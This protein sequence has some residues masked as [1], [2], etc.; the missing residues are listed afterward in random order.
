MER[1]GGASLHE[2]GAGGAFGFSGLEGFA[3]DADPGFAEAGEAAGM[4]DFSGAVDFAGA[5]SSVDLGASPRRASTI[6][7]VPVLLI[8]QLR[9]QMRHCASV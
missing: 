4:L 2:R 6:F 1:F 3:G 5:D 8:L 7:S 9:S